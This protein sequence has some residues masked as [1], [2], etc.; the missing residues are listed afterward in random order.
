MRVCGSLK[1]KDIVGSSTNK[2]I[3]EAPR[4]IDPTPVCLLPLAKPHRYQLPQPLKEPLLSTPIETA[5]FVNAKALPE[6][7]F[8]RTLARSSTAPP[9]TIF[10]CIA[11]LPSTTDEAGVN[12]TRV[13]V[14]YKGDVGLLFLAEPS[15]NQYACKCLG[16]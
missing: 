7:F 5:L 2:K 4:F 15:V 6:G 9:T 3:N 10:S 11:L 1:N 13:A 8:K 12:S 16:H 14:I